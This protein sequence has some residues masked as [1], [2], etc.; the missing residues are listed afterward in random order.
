MLLPSHLY[1]EEVLLFTTL[2][3]T[4]QQASQILS[5]MKLKTPMDWKGNKGQSSRHAVPGLVTGRPGPPLLSQ[6]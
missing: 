1:L 6:G 4:E 2:P 5:S 3:I